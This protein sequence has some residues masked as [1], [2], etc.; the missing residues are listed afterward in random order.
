MLDNQSIANNNRRRRRIQYRI[1]S[2]SVF[3]FSH[4]S[5]INHVFISHIILFE[6]RIGNNFYFRF[7]VSTFFNKK[8]NFFMLQSITRYICW[9]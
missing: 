1:L 4:V 8:K 6:I 7:T 3:L 9:H 2:M 5:K